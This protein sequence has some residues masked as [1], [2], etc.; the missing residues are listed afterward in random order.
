[1]VVE[2]RNDAT[3]AMSVVFPVSMMGFGTAPIAETWS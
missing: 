2:E 1:L 3:R